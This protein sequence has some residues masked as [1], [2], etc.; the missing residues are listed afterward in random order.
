MLHVQEA[1]SFCILQASIKVC[2]QVLS[3]ILAVDLQL[4]IVLLLTLR[5][6]NYLL[7]LLSVHDPFVR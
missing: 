5:P 1:L 3:H 6:T 2:H 4:D 7:P